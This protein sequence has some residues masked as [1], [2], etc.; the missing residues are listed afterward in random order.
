MLVGVSAKPRPPLDPWTR[1][2][3]GLWTV[4]C[5]LAARTRV[6]S[7]VG[8]KETEGAGQTAR[9]REA[10][11]GCRC[12]CGVRSLPAYYLPT[13]VSTGTQIPEHLRVVLGTSG[14]PV[15][16]RLWYGVAVGRGIQSAVP[17]CQ[18]PRLPQT[19]RQ[20][21]SRF[22]W[23]N[24]KGCSASAPF[25]HARVPAV[26]PV[27]CTCSSFPCRFACFVR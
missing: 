27:P 20:S 13:E 21:Y 19:D 24:E 11:R 9:H 8:E 15:R 23:L 25:Y 1:K 16:A 10:C 2:K 6:R 14:C 7:R 26:A 4:H 22:G 3:T 18:T 12:K 5:G 17:D